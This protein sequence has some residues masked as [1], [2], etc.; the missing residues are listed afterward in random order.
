[1]DY[2][3]IVTSLYQTLLL[4]QPDED[5][6][7]YW[8]EQLENGTL[9]TGGVAQNFMM[10]NE[11]DTAIQPIVDLYQTY[12]LRPADIDGL[13]YWVE[14]HRQGLSIDDITASLQSSAEFEAIANQESAVWLNQAYSAFL[15]RSP[16][17]ESTDFWLAQLASGVSRA[18]VA[19]TLAQSYES[20]QLKSVQTLS[21]LSNTGASSADFEAVLGDITRRIEDEATTPIEQ[22]DQPVEEP[23]A[24]VEEPD[25]PIEEPEEPVEEPEAPI[26]EPDEP[27]EEPE[28]PIEE[29][30]EPVEE[31]EE[32][33]EEPEEPVEE[34]EEP[35]EEPEEP[36]EEPEQT[37]Q[38]DFQFGE[39]YFKGASDASAAVAISETLMLV[40][41]D[42][43]QTLRLYDREDGG[44]PVKSFDLNQALGLSEGQEADLEAVATHEGVQ[45]WLGSHQSGQRSM[46]F[47]TEVTGSGDDL[48]I[49]VV[50]QFTDLNE[51]LLSWDRG[52]G[53]GLGE[54]ALKLELGINVEGA[55]FIDDALYLGLRAPLDDGFA[56]LIPVENAVDLV[57]GS[58]READFGTPL[59]LDLDGRAVRAIEPAGDQGYLILAGPEDDSLE[60]GFGL[61]FWDGDHAVREI[62][63]VDLNTIPQAIGAKPESIFDIAISDDGVSASV[64]FDSGTVDWFE[65]GRESKDLPD[66][67]QQFIGLDIAFEALPDT[68]PRPGDI[69]VIAVSGSDKEFQFVALKG[70]SEGA[71]ITFTDSGW[72]EDGFRANEGAV[73]WTAPEGG[74]APG[75]VISSVNNADQ[76]INAN[77]PAVGN[78][79]FNLST[80][81]DQVIAF[82]GEDTA[83]S[84]IY[85]VQTN[86]G[87]WQ[88]TASSSN[89]SALP[90]G[91][92][93]G[94]T[95][96]AV[97]SAKNAAFTGEGYGTVDALLSVI[98][99]PDNWEFASSAMPDGLTQAFRIGTMEAPYV[100]GEADIGLAIT[101]IWPGQS[102][103]D[104]TEDWFEITNR[105]DETLDFTSSPL[106]YDDDSASPQDAV[107]IE[108]LTTLAP[109]ESA[110][111]IVDGG[112]DAVGE[113]RA[114]WSNLSGIESLKIGFADD[115]AGLGSGGDAVTLWQGDP[116]VD[117]NRI[118]FEAYPDTSDHDAASWNVDRQAFTQP[119]EE[120]ALASSALGGDGSDVPALAS[121]GVAVEPEVALTLISTV[122]GEGGTSALDGESVTLEAIVTMVTPGL[123]GF[124]LQEEDADNDDNP[125]TSE[126]IFVYA[127]SG[128]AE[129][130]ATL[131]AG[132]QIRIGGTVSEYYDKTQLT[133]ERSSLKILQH[134]QPLPQ[135]KVIKLPFANKQGLEAFE[136]M[137]VAIEAMDGQPLVVTELY[138]LGRYGEVT[139]SAGGRL[140]QFTEVNAPSVEGYQAWLEDAEA[141][142]IKLDDANSSQNPD[143]IIHGR[144][145]EEL[146]ASNPLRG[147]DTLETLD[148]VL[149]FNF[150]EW[151]VQNVE[152]LDFQGSDR[153]TAPDVEALGDATIKVASFN[154]LNY[155]NTLGDSGQPTRTLDGT[156]HSP[157]GADNAEEFA[158]QEAK[159]VEAINT[160]GADVLGLM[161]IENNGYGEDSALASLVNAL[162]ADIAA[163]GIEGITWAYS[164]PRDGDG[165][166]VSAG[167]DAI[168]V[169]VIYNSQA[170]TPEGAAATTTEG[171]FGYGNRPPVMQTFSDENG[172]QFS[173]VVNHFKSKGSV[174]NGEDAIGD[175]Q[176]NNNPTRVEAAKELM[177]WLETNPTGSSDQD[178]LILGDLNA[179]AMEDPIMVLVE[180]G[181]ELL[182]DDYSYVFDGFWGSL[183]HALA[184]E[185][186]AGQVT[187]TTTWHINA[188]E[189][190]ALDYNTDFTSE[191]QDENLYAPD[192]F[193][194]SD[195]DPILVGLNLGGGEF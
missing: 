90:P 195:H 50:G 176:G 84:F 96:V 95:A 15:G 93:E 36:I 138:E 80:G 17:P 13:A 72:Q 62:E 88:A 164:I 132:D 5:G 152:G 108:G 147:G 89:D 24:P 1:M 126:G 59:R 82:V 75:T 77:S 180:G 35:V 69:A 187:G 94:L 67:Q 2:Q 101:E 6:L 112:V 131:S 54:S 43:D 125:N 81:G 91:L 70:I 140:E 87:E 12:L 42:E 57:N 144:G 192:A 143:P 98:A 44:E 74:V 174:I 186:L 9:D 85:A 163:K 73:K 78:N 151:K 20:Q 3:T 127:G 194:S 92:E 184:S 118:G 32:P 53:H 168:T 109:G 116:L 56:Q 190:S 189:A 86:S 185:S 133:A 49:N 45:Y 141:R 175:G 169:G 122:Q 47:A 142:T 121:P 39:R 46:V 130:L 191:R 33:I 193:R 48:E 29:P 136:G 172:E 181:F 76:F 83:P 28:E 145:G 102:G 158:R 106:Y 14:M 148:G 157:R 40:A 38:P 124:F 111:V 21:T 41:D 120:G 66:A 100:P 55:V 10:G 182:D 22:P 51:Q 183:D 139:L 31:P 61:Y 161:E 160:S 150:G 134:D 113:F 11:F 153:P 52:N 103:S 97:G 129:W 179:Y 171:A 104:I 23:E 128:S 154:V 110:I 99:N 167:D 115:A 119:D 173:V 25:E 105:S 188:D 166:I 27:V 65:D 60:T 34:P 30:E 156:T 63:G 146:S 177:A 18:D 64:L 19:Q 107:R 8:V 16:D 123:D 7:S 135:S 165:N 178:V 117:G 137:R 37:P 159:I 26:E 58:A 149:D 155:F 170:V 71:E 114:A 68:T 4:R 79:G 162:N